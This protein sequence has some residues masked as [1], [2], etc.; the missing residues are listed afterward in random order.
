MPAN[1]KEYQKIYR[2]KNRNTRKVVSVSL[3]GD[4][5]R[6]ITR[7]A[8]KQG[9]SVSALLREASLHQCRG[10]Q[11]NSPAVQSDL[12]ELRFLLSNIANNVNQMAHHSNRLRHVVDEN[13]V[14]SNLAELD[15]LLRTFVFERMQHR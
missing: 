5:H 12:R 7:Y 2:A 9:L 14:L 15:E 11:I 3:S 6:N 10:S 4:D 8:K 13:G 1:S